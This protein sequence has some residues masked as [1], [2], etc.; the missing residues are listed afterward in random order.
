M[1]AGPWRIRLRDAV[2]GLPFRVLSI[3]LAT[4]S[5]LFIAWRWKSCCS[6]PCR[7]EPKPTA[8]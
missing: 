7:F 4:P 2:E 8:R 6:T 5:L 3:R 1:D